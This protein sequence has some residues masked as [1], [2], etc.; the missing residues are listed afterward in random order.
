M[1]HR[2]RVPHFERASDRHFW[3]ARVRCIQQPINHNAAVEMDDGAVLAA[4]PLEQRIS[5][6]FVVL[7]DSIVVNGVE[8]VRINCD[9]L[10]GV[11]GVED[12]GG[13]AVELLLRACGAVKACAV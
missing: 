9:A 2:S 12:P 8:M 6:S 10:T 11:R 3:V 13:G 4:I 7:G 5:G 1:L